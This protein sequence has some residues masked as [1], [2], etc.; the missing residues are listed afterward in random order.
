MT[1]PCTIQLVV[2]LL[3]TRIGVPNV[4]GLET[5]SWDALGVESLGLT[6]ICTGLEHNL[7]ITLSLE[8]VLHTKNVQ[9]L[10]TFVNSLAAT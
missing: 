8:E 5:I 10:V 6:E 7:G 1:S 4:D 2:E 3:H 9:E